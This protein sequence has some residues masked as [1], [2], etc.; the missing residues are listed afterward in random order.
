MPEADLEELTAVAKRDR[1][2]ADVAAEVLRTDLLIRASSPDDRLD[3]IVLGRWSWLAQFDHDDL[4]EFVTE[5]ATAII[6]NDD[7]AVFDTL[8]GWQ[9]SAAALADPERMSVLSAGLDEDD[10]VEVPRPDGDHAV[11]GSPAVASA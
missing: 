6:K 4:C 9:E 3:P 1:S 8:S 2:M 10:Y 11:A 7:L 5:M